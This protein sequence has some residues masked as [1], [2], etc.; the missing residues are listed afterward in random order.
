MTYGFQAI[1]AYVILNKVF[2]GVTL[3]AKSIVCAL[4]TVWKAFAL[5]TSLCNFVVVITIIAFCAGRIITTFLA[6][7]QTFLAC[8]RK[9]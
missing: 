8:I 4:Q 2:L 7:I 5:I 6:L 3:S 9:S 1:C